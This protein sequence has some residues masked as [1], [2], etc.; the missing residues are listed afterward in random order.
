M[1]QAIWKYAVP[2]QDMITLM[3]PR[4]AQVLTVQVQHGEPQLWALVDPDNPPEQRT[5][6]LAGTGHVIEGSVN[7]FSYVG[8]YQLDDGALVFHL[9]E[10]FLPVE[11]SS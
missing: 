3:I 7:I 1:S 2:V 11:A 4:N 8:T 6:R 5:F 9:F 10:L